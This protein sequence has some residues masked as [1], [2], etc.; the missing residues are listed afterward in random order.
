[1]TKHAFFPVAEPDL[2]CL[3]EE[4]LI[5]AFRSGWISSI[6]GFINRFEKDFA[7]FCRVDN[8]IAVSNGTVALHLAL[9]ILGIG[10]GD[11]VIMPALTFAA[12]AAAVCYRG[13]KPVF[14]DSEPDIGTI[15]PEMVKEAISPKTKAIIAVHLYGHPASMQ[16]IL[17]LAKVRDLPVIED[18]AEA[19]GAQYKGRPVG[20][21]GHMATFS[22]YGN[23]ILTTGE[24]GMLVTNNGELAAS[25]RFYKDHAMDPNR[26]YWHSAVGYN[27]RMTNLQ[28]AVG[29]A[30]LERFDEMLQK[31]KALLSRYREA[32]ADCRDILINPS[33]T[34]ARP[35]P[36]LICAIL[37]EGT[38]GTV[39]DKLMARLREQGVDTRPYFH[40]LC[41]MP[42]YK[43]YRT[44]SRQG[45]I[46][47]VARDLSQR[48]MNLPTLTDPKRDMTSALSILHR[49]I[50]I[51]GN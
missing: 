25:A 4:Y 16:K 38:T 28:A 30:Q 12:V 21:I 45:K 15:D 8:A 33:R 46:C 7:S 20:S 27:Y 13:A 11:E 37:P 40:L 24:G 41:D 17:D 29:C 23:K 19:H 22:F 49:E 2:S 10:K 1:M 14:V 31:R 43:K 9:T 48:G 35:V 39:R 18:A 42:P 3:E 51:L 5:E 32:L 26:R 6:G 50:S 36:W 47:P 44:V 34:W